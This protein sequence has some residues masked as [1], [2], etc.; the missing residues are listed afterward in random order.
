MLNFNFWYGIIYAYT[1][2][3]MSIM[4][5][6]LLATVFLFVTIIQVN[7]QRLD[8]ENTSKY[9]W[10]VNIG[11]TWHTTDV[12]N[13]NV[14]D[15]FPLGASLI[16]GR[17]FNQDYGKT[18]SFDVRGR[19]LYGRWYGQDR[20]TTSILPPYEP[21]KG[22]SDSLGYGI[23]NFRASQLSLDIELSMHLNSLK[24][25]TGWDPYIFAGIGIVG[26]NSKAE[27]TADKDLSV[28]DYKYETPLTANVVDGLDESY[29]KEGL[30]G[31]ILPSLGVGIGYYFNS[32]FSLGLEHRTTFF[33]SDYLDGTTVNNLGAE[34][35]I[36][37]DLYHYTSIYFKWYFKLKKDR[38]PPVTPGVVDPVVTDNPTVRTP[39]VVRFTNPNVSGTTVNNPN[40]TIR[41]NIQNVY[42][43]NDLTFLQN[44]RRI[45]S[46]Y[47]NPSNRTFESAVVLQLGSNTFKLTGTNN[48][49][50]S[51]DQTVV[52]YKED[53]RAYPPIVNIV[54]P[55][56]SP[57]TVSQLSY[58][59]KAS[60]QNIQNKNQLKV[61]FNDKSFTAFSFT[62]TGNINF[63]ANL[64]L[65]AGVNV[66]NIVGTNEAGV[67]SDQTVLI[68]NRQPA[69]N[70]YPPTVNIVI[71]SISPYST[72]NPVENVVAT[73][74]NV[75]NKNQIGVKVNGVNTTNFTYNDNNKT[76]QFSAHLLEGNNVVSVNAANNY[77][78]AT[79]DANII[80]RAKVENYPPAVT[81]TTPNVNPYNSS[82]PTAN[83]TAF[84]QNIDNKNQI[85]V[86]VNGASTSNFTFNNST[87][88]VQFTASLLEGN[89]NVRIQ[90]AN[91]YGSAS[92]ERQLIYKRAVKTP[93]TVTIT[94]PILNPYT[95]SNTS[96]VVTAYVTN[97][98]A[99]S[100]IE[101]RVNGAAT[102]NFA[103]NSGTKTV[104][105]TANLTGGNNVIRVTATNND[106]T[107]FA[108][109]NITMRKPV[110]S[111]P[112]VT[113]TKPI[114]NP[115]TT[116][117]TSE[118]VTA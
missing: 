85:E 18:I 65:T 92:D 8:Y 63:S 67:D 102:S 66:L 3:N 36:K 2:R 107:A 17:S 54:D 101:V 46:F 31:N 100:Q 99:K 48:D 84:V 60:I 104:Q 110:Q 80:Y 69:E 82:L 12:R 86:R 21:Y 41:A 61:T 43:S 32:R 34:S 62:P 44:G 27:M 47:Y 113:I 88:L 14:K 79:D 106:G 42:N 28:K 118:V 39:P 71:P 117:N 11:H 35:K 7:A 95:T 70:A 5:K 10:G 72:T 56:S 55:A 105:L 23:K 73:V 4:K 81:I 53:E 52:I 25:R 59:V 90:V 45:T 26:T 20:D 87:K 30:K 1:K 51:T 37:N 22:L 112:T 103:F 74:T 64:N 97:I 91:N 16:V 83:V 58:I 40:Y 109:T 29:K 76:V 57:H 115:Y 13:I 33:R 6:I 77:G 114:L 94:K 89:N 108:E 9:F 116:S 50:T 24:E 49:G 68:Y 15:R 98:T 96:E 111:P 38:Q 93:P 19:L 78:S 75:N